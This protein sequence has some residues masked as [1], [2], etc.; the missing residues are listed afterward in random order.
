MDYK[1]STPRNHNIKFGVPRHHAR[2]T[3]THV[4]RSTSGG[5]TDGGTNATLSQ[6]IIIGELSEGTLLNVYTIKD[7]P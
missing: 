5:T 4:L 2:G 1:P 7:K 6:G 3:T